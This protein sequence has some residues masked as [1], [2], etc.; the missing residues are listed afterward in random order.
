MELILFGALALFSTIIL[1]AV[2]I[3]AEP[4]CR[5]QPRDKRGRFMKFPD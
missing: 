1:L 4:K 3:P 2:C 5:K